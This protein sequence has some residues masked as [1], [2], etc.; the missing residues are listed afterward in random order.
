MRLLIPFAA[1][2]WKQAATLPQIDPGFTLETLIVIQTE[3][4]DD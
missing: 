3:N 4:Y 1:S 2:K